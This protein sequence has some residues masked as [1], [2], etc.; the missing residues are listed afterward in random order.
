MVCKSG[1]VRSPKSGK[2]IKKS[3][4]RK[5][6][7]RKSPRRRSRRSPTYRS[8]TMTAPNKRYIYQNGRYFMNP[9]FQQHV[10]YV[11]APPMQA[12]RG[13]FGPAP[14]GGMGGPGM[15]PTTPSLATGIF[16]PGEGII[17]NASQS[18]R[19]LATLLPDNNRL[20]RR[21]L[22]AR[23]Q[24]SVRSTPMS[25][26]NTVG[27]R[28]PASARGFAS[29]DTNLALPITGVNPS[30][31]TSPERIVAAVAN[32]P[33][34]LVRALSPPVLP[35]GGGLVGVISGAASAVG[36][37]LGGLLNFSPRRTPEA[38]ADDYARAEGSLYGL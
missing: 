4:K 20:P 19:S 9:N 12:W 17:S 24:S 15:G 21:T 33:T 31:A 5:S 1:K 25:S 30:A 34:T 26:I 23:T 11:G 37:A 14:G 6:P 28:S 3:P 38:L 36:S 13:P 29:R 27:V 22:F 16:G 32:T 7:K 35:S 18:L 2:C 10:P 8:L